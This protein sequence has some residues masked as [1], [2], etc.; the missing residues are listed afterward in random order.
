MADRGEDIGV[1]MAGGQSVGIAV[2]QAQNHPVSTAA[3][4]T[5]AHPGIAAGSVAGRLEEAPRRLAGRKGQGS[6]LVVAS[7]N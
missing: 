3:G 4:R 2:G 5:N 6:L 1:E 7:E